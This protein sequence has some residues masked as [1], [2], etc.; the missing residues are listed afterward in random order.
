MKTVPIRGGFFMLSPLPAS[1]CHNAAHTNFILDPSRLTA[2][3]IYGI[4]SKK[5]IEKNKINFSRK[6]RGRKWE[7]TILLDLCR[8]PTADNTKKFGPKRREKRAINR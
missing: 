5:N 4:L 3:G 2:W 8:K 6:I 1:R 7:S